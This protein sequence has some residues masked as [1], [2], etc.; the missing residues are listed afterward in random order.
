MKRL[1]P[2]CLSLL[3]LA[4]ACSVEPGEP[5]DHSTVQSNLPPVP[6]PANDPLTEEKV[7][8][9]RR[10]FYDTRLSVDGTVSCASCHRQEAAFA[11]AGRQT[12]VGVRGQFG[13]R[14]SPMIVNSAYQPY[15]F[16]DGRAQTLEEQ[17]LAAFLS[18][19][20]MAADTVAVAALLRSADYRDRWMAAFGDTT[21]SM[22]MAMRAISAF[23]RTLIS[24]NSPYDRYVRG[25]GTA[26]TASQK[27][28]MSLFFSNRSM[29]SNCHGGPNF[30]DHSFRNVGLFRHYFDR[31][32]YSVTKDPDDEA[33]F[34]TPTLRNIALTPPYMAGGDSDDG[35]L[36]TLEAVVEHYDKGGFKFH[37]QDDR[38]RK[39]SLTP[40][41]KAD[42]V[43]FMHALTDSTVLTNP[44]F[45]KP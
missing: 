10:L 43:A 37:N 1:L 6:V 39:L 13:N 28:G 31:G 15:F 9:G 19:T 4:A 17:A 11:D 33:L 18:K 29:C 26:M 8:L 14:N 20:E 23:E 24:A 2:I 44:R 41:Q 30:T 38:V 45:A 25:D 42:L 27:R 5:V 12:S 21:V 7:E 36:W 40:E 35:E 22:L 34:K 16:W 32:R 3:T